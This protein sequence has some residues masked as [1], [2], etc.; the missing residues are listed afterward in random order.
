MVSPGLGGSD[1]LDPGGLGE[2]GDVGGG[3]RQPL[4]GGGLQGQLALFTIVGL[5]R[6]I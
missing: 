3:L 2:F 5:D 1:V 4:G 6:H